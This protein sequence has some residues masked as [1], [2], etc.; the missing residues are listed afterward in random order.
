MDL[1]TPFLTVTQLAAVPLVM[2]LVS[3]LKNAKVAGEE[4][5]W[6]PIISVALGSG[7]VWL[8]PSAT[9]QATV[10]AGLT[11]G[12]IAAGVYSGVKTTVAPD[13]K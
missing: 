8:V 2:A 12:V 5:R 3:L 1:T 7:L 4:N 6:A 9:W 11:V 10:L 13:A